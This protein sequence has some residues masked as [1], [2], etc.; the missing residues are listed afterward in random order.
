PVN[1]MEDGRVFWSN[2][3][4]LTDVTSSIQSQRGLGAS[5]VAVPS[6]GG[7]I[8]IQTRT[9]D[10]K[11]GG[12]IYQGLG[13]DGYYKTTFSYSTGLT[14]KGWAFSA[15]GSRNISNGY[16]NGLAYEAYSYFFNASKVINENH[17]L[18]LT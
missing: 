10:A 9:T 11:Q 13:N 17:T 2:W 6:I 4:G 12:F 1:D 7:T 5:K 8:N 15:M 16:V 3:S 14:D 18:S